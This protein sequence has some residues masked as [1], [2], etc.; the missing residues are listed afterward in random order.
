MKACMAT[1]F[2]GRQVSVLCADGRL[3]LCNFSLERRLRNFRVGRGEE[4]RLIPL[5]SIAEVYEGIEPEGIAT[6]LDELCCTMGLD[7]G[8]CITFRFDSLSERATFATTL[9]A[10]TDYQVQ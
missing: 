1:L 7:S 9:R 5:S 4:S 8:E 2:R 6:P 10:L 3:R